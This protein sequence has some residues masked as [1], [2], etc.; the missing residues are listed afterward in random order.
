MTSSQ[1]SLREMAQR[2]L[3]AD[4]KR[5]DMSSKQVERRMLTIRDD[6]TKF[7]ERYGQSGL[8]VMPGGGSFG[9]AAVAIE[10]KHCKMTHRQLKIEHKEIA[11]QQQD[12]GPKDPLPRLQER[13]QQQ[14]QIQH[15]QQEQLQKKLQQQQE[16]IQ[17]LQIQNQQQE[18]QQ[19][20]QIQKL[21]LQLQQ[22]RL[23]QEH[24]RRL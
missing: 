11:S 1:L 10:A 6:F 24:P 3:M 13:R 22:E 16:Q 8:R 21:Q 2:A 14:L 17:K 19:Q 20:E 12:D 7:A 4:I 15:Q 9:S 5:D 23:Q 18:Q